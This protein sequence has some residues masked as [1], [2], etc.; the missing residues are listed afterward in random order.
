MTMF[1]LMGKIMM[2]KQ[3]RTRRILSSVM[4]VVALHEV[5]FTPTCLLETVNVQKKLLQSCLQSHSLHTLNHIHPRWILSLQFV[6]VIC[7]LFLFFFQR[8]GEKKREKSGL[9]KQNVSPYGTRFSVAQS[10]LRIARSLCHS[11]YG[12][13]FRQYKH[14]IVNKGESRIGSAI[15]SV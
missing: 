8:A 9:S 11:L 4:D 7:C 13:G 6:V 14:C 10:A 2:F 5:I 12:T 1:A 15:S 3:V